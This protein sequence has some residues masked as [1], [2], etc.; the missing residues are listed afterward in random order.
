MP[1]AGLL[2]RIGERKPAEPLSPQM[3]Q[4]LVEKG[5]LVETNGRGV[6]SPSDFM[7][8]KRLQKHLDRLQRGET[9]SGSES[10]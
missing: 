7:G 3:R 8:K 2:T 5:L 4:T 6:A 10:Q 1:L 9:T